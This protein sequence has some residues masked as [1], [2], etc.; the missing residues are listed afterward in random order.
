VYAKL[1]AMIIQH[2]L[3]LLTCWDEMDH[4]LPKAA[5]AIRWAHHRLVGAL[6]DVERVMEMLADIRKGCKANAKTQEAQCL[7]I[8]A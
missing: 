6:A 5:R 2:W 8:V 3:L 7:P 4:S 1:I